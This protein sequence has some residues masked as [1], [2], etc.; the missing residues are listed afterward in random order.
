MSTIDR[1]FVRF[2]IPKF[3]VERPLELGEDVVFQGTGTVVN[4]S[5]R[6]MHNGTIDVTTTIKPQVIEVKKA[7]KGIIAPHPLTTTGVPSG[8]SLSQ[9]YRDKLYI[10]YRQKF[11]DSDP[12]L[13]ELYYQRVMEERLER[14]E[15]KI[16]ELNEY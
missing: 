2:T 8:K 13:F 15:D 10:Y 12:Q 1:S 7:E 16:D 4:R 11:K 3:E 5:E 6:D 9:Q 14:L